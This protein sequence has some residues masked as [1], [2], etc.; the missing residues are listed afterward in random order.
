MHLFSRGSSGVFEKAIWFGNPIGLQKGSWLLAAGSKSSETSMPEIEGLKWELVKG[1][2]RLITL[3][4]TILANGVGF[5]EGS[6]DAGSWDYH[7]S[8][9]W[10]LPQAENTSLPCWVRPALCPGSSITTVNAKRRYDVEGVSLSEFWAPF[11]PAW[12]RKIHPT[13]NHTPAS[14]T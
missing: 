14:T 3:Y 4:Q 5:C 10:V 6:F 8:G 7:G 12:Q 9:F 2:Q 11:E 1:Q 13:A